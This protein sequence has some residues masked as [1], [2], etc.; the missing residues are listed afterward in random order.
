MERT[1]QRREL[2]NQKLGKTPD[3][4]PRKRVLEDTANLPPKQPLPEDGRLYL[5]APH[6][7]TSDRD[8]F[9]KLFA[10]RSGSVGRALDW[11]SEGCWFDLIAGEVSVL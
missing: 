6:H 1:R 3:P 2:L 4:A 10:E 5:H 7:V 11:G 9:L 8:F